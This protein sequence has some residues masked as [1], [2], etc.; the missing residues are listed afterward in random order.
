M[1]RAARNH[2]RWS[3]EVTR[4]ARGRPRV[5]SPR[6]Y[7]ALTRFDSRAA[8]SMSAATAAGCDT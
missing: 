3:I 7:F 2:D 4:H 6:L 1:S 5:T 8:L